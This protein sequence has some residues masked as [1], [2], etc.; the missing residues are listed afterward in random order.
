MLDVLTIV[1][2]VIG[3]GAIAFLVYVAVQPSDFR[4]ARTAEI[5]APADRIFPLIND[6][7]QF[8]RWNPFAKADPTSQITYSG[9]AQG[10]GAAFAW[11]GAKSGAGQM[12][13]ATSVP[14]SQVTMQLDFTKPFTAHNRAEFSVVPRGGVSV[15]TWAMTGR[16]PFSHKLIG[17]VFNMDRMVGKEFSKG[18]ADLKSLAEAKA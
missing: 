2:A 8:N 6:L 13:I 4:I 9:P 15:V 3:L 5:A 18:L 17:A 10:V 16:R 14:S 11:A 12:K 7:H 1:L